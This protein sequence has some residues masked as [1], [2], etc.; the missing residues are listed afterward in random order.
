MRFSVV[1]TYTAVFYYLIT[2]ILNEKIGLS[3]NNS[4][5]ISLI[6]AVIFQYISHAIFTFRKK[7]LMFDQIQRF[8][9]TI[10]TGSAISMMAITAGQYT[11]MNR[12]F[13][14][15]IIML[16][17]PVVNWLVFSRWVFTDDHDD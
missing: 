3:L 8:I 2:V 13:A 6:V 7:I 1:G 4:S 15:L 10:S 17:T 12:S 14:L 9:I 11:G 16:T 5:L